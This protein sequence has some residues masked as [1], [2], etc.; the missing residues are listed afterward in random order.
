M[1]NRTT[2]AH[3]ANQA[4]PRIHGAF[5]KGCPFLRQPREVGPP[6]G[7]HTGPG[8]RGGTRL[9]GSSSFKGNLGL[10]YEFEYASRPTFARLNYAHVGSYHDYISADTA[11][12]GGYNKLDARAGII[13]ENV[14]LEIYASNLL[15]EDAITQ[16]LSDPVIAYQLR[17][18][19]IGIDM[20]FRF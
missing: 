8:P 14:E 7:P 1:P 3:R 15:N 6:S 10:Q 16:V 17:P 4:P 9:P 19:T 13:L 11:E 5:L 18:R 20:R 12:A 2:A